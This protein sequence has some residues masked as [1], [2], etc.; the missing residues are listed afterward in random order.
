MKIRA[1]ETIR[2]ED[3]PN[4]LLVQ[5]HSDDLVGLGETFFGAAAAE[6][7]IHESVAPYLLGK[8]PRRMELHARRLTGYVGFRTAGVETRGNSAID[9][10]LWD[11]AGQA[12][13]SSLTDM[14]GGPVNGD[15]PVYNTCAGP[16]YVRRSVEVKPSNWGIEETPQDTRQNTPSEY[17]DLDA[18]L[19][20]PEALAKS[21]Q[22]QSIG[23]MKIWPFDPA[24]IRSSGQE[25]T[26]LELETAVEPIRRVRE[27]VGRDIDVMIELHGLWSV[28]AARLIA[29]ALEPYGPKW[30]EDPTRVHDF[31]ALNQVRSAT[32]IPIAA[33]ET[34]GG[35]A[36]F[37]SL[38]DAGGADVAIVDV[39][40]AGGVTEAR[41]VADLA[42]ERSVQVAFH[43]CSGPVTFVASLH[44]AATS[45]TAATQE[46]VRAFLFGWH[47]D[48]VTQLPELH[49]GH[50]RPPTGPGLGI[51]LQADLLT[52]PG[53]S[54]RQSAL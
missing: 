14:L 19:H 21:L 30:I 5:V 34:L 35:S 40:W 54:V 20:R 3:Y 27:A 45:R 32:G 10:A 37:R 4:L 25:I 41:R 17:E 50:V 51:A 52:R 33:G 8:N 1:I 26:P 44:L 53:V 7:Y 42:N 11:L 47:R 15:I 39:S 43:N 22:S 46:I 28:T 48:L 38:L 18:F 13:G 29:R 36:S 16:S 23:G 9:I 2:L 49:D 31:A 24:A 12:A 6:A